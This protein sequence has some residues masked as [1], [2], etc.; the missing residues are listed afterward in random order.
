MP[1]RINNFKISSTLVE[2]GQTTEGYYPFK[3]LTFR[4]LDQ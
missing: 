4:N 1:K 2:R 3:Y